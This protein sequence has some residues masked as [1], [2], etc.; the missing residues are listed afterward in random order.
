VLEKVV[1]K[2]IDEHPDEV[3]SYKHGKTQLMGFFV[4]EIM[5]ATKGLANP[6]LVNKLLRSKLI[7]K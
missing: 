7:C 5:K 2:V 4:G 1:Q 3:K 6:K